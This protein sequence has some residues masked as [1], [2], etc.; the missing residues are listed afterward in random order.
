MLH[1]S[2][3]YLLA[4]T[5]AFGVS[6]QCFRCPGETT[7]L[8]PCATGKVMKTPVMQEHQK[9]VGVSSSDILKNSGEAK[10][11]VSLRE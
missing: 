7:E 2:A 1:Q 6:R 10:I 5:G 4:C 8:P 11:W 9:T 3:K